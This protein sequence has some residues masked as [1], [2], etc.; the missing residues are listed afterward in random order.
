MLDKGRAQ[1]SATTRRGPEG[2]WGLLARPLAKH[3]GQNGVVRVGAD[4]VG[5]PGVEPAGNSG[6]TILISEEFPRA[7][8]SRRRKEAV[9]GRNSMGRFHPGIGS[10][11]NARALRGSR[12]GSWPERFQTGHGRRASPLV[13]RRRLA[14]FINAGF[15]RL[16][17]V[18]NISAHEPTQPC[19]PTDGPLLRIALRDKG[20]DYPLNRLFSSLWEAEGH[21]LDATCAEGQLT[22]ETC[23]LPSRPGPRREGG[24]ILRA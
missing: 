18:G 4:A 6:D 8:R 7:F 10:R 23:P 24:P 12:G 13:R 15:V 19:A 20:S 17:A 21:V 1:A 2:S 14:S 9:Q 3:P 16:G 22:I 11:R 5:I